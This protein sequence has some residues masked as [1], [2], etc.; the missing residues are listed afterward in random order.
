MRYAATKYI[1]HK[2]QGVIMTKLETK[3]AEALSRVWHAEGRLYQ[4]VGVGYSVK[5]IAVQDRIRELN[6]RRKELNI[7]LNENT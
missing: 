7:F 4:C 1:T 2:P 6:A 3:I 5:S